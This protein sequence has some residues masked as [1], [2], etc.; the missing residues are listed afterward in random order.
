M[1]ADLSNHVTIRVDAGIRLGTLPHNWT[2]IGYDE[3]NYTY[4]PD[5]RELLAK[6]MVL[7]DGPYYVRAHHLLCTGNCHGV[8]KWGSTNAYL[9]D[10]AGDPIY[11][12]TFVDL[13]L[14]TILAH[15]C[16]P[17]VELGFMPLDLADTSCYDP[18][19]DTWTLQHYRTYG[20]ACPPKDYQKWYDLIYQLVTHCAD[21]YGVD[22][23]RSWY[24]EL[25]NEP[26]L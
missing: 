6:F 8:P 22:E 17:F 13:V 9:E 3:I 14:D 1:T 5:G 7:Q 4:T 10:A 21:R 26:D 2:Y 16:K 11:D 23:I 25:W 18:A 19:Q 15:R 20:W 12:W 24:W